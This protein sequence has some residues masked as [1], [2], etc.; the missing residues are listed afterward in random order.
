MSLFGRVAQTK[1]GALK[2]IDSGLV[3]RLCDVGFLKERYIGS[4]TSS[5][6]ALNT[7]QRLL[8]PVLQLL[9]TILTTI[10]QQEQI[11]IQAVIFSRIKAKYYRLTQF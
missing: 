9:L 3:S 7:F 4:N 8:H 10:G 6:Y 5:N 2:L 1:E 11:G